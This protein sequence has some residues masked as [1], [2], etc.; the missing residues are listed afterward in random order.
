[1][2][3]TLY[4]A[5]ACLNC[6]GILAFGGSLDYPETET[7]NQIDNFHGTEVADPYRWLE[8]DVRESARV[9]AWV[10]QQNA[11][12]FE[13]LAKLSTREAFKKK[14]EE[15]WNFER[16]SLPEKVGGRYF[17][18]RNDGLQNQSVLYV[19]EELDGEPRV[20][21][22]PNTLSEEGTVSLARYEISD[23]GKLM[24][25]ALAESG[26]DWNTWYVMDVET[27]EKLSD[28]I[29]FT[30]F[31][32]AVWTKD[33]KGFFY[34]RFPEPEDDFQDLNKNQKVYYHR[35]GTKQ[36]EDTLVYERPDEPEWGFNNALSDDG[37]YLVMTVWKGTAEKYR[38]Y[39]KDLEDE[40]SAPVAL[41]DHFEHEFSFLGNDGN[42]FYF[43]TDK[44]APMRKV[45]AIDITNPAPEHWREIIP[46]AESKLEGI[47]LVNSLFVANYLEDVKS[48]VRI[49]DTQGTYIR[50]VELT[51]IGSAGGF[52][53]ERH[54]TETFYAFQSFNVPPTIYRYNLITGEQEIF[55]QPKVKFSPET[56]EVQQVFYSSK[57]G[58][59]IPMFIVSKKGI[60]LNGE[61]PTILYGYGG[62][63]I[64]LTPRFSVS[65]LAWV[66][67]GGVVAIAN[68]RGGGEYGEEWHQAGTKLNK[69]NVFDD[70]IYAAKW[71]IAND[72][73]K[74]ARLGIIGRSNGGLLIGAVL[75]QA[76]ELFG[77][78]IPEVGVMDMLRFHRFTAGRYWVDDYGSAENP[79]EFQALYAYSPYHTIKEIAYPPTLVTTA[80]TDDRVVPGHSFKYI[81]RLQEAH[82]GEA[83]VLIRIETSAGHGGGTPITKIIEQIADNWAFFAEHLGLESL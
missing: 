55:R 52:G 64:S 21:L 75:N 41:V 54:D 39:Y 34:A 9:K 76:P 67:M 81:A 57:D 61:N 16:Y 58:T 42:E 83:P 73:T 38:V 2:K 82:Q 49:Y 15:L 65:W 27:G 77:A 53:G 3:L 59:K 33:N 63:N 45:I 7:V 68:L 18:R 1:M 36:A 17:Y 29:H 23:D 25:Y 40:R 5:V 14:L 70:F 13:Y 44:D 11:V 22:D 46:E 6:V 50:D 47:S 37:R 10:D 48:R 35:V 62:F 71:L 19:L 72:Y 30:K 32:S 43:A 51:G 74:P 69:Q 28:E 78:A 31:T 12:T 26:S 56:L 4:I 24:A 60:Q 79:E 66:E 20:L 8:E 80:D